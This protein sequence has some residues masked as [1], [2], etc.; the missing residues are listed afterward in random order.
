V[1]VTAFA[2]RL[3]AIAPCFE[4]AIPTLMA[5]C[6]RDGVPNISTVSHVHRVDERRVAI[7]RQF[8]NKTQAN[9]RENPQASI[10]M[11]DPI[12]LET[13]RLALRFD[14]EETSGPLFEAM[15]ARLAAIASHVGMTGVFRLQASVVFEVLSVERVEGT[16]VDVVDAPPP[17][18]AAAIDA[19]TQ[20]R[21]LRRIS[22]CLRAT[23]DAEALLDSVLAIL[24]EV[25]GFEH[26]MIL[27]LDETG[28]RLY[29][30]ASRGYPESG[31][32][33]EVRLGEGIIGKVAQTRRLLRVGNL[34]SEGR[35]AR[36]ARST[37]PGAEAREI[38]LP[39]LADAASQLAIPLVAQ[40]ELLGVLAVESR[41]WARY[42]ERDEAFLDVVAGHVALG[43][44]NAVRQA[45]AEPAPAVATASPARA[46]SG[47][48]H[49]FAFYP[50]DDCVFLDG[51]YL[52]RNVPG[53]ILWK[54]LEAYTKGG[55][56]DFTNREL[57]LDATLGL[58]ELRDNLESRLILLRKR[59]AERCEGVRIVSAGRGRF[60]LEVRGAI[61]LEERA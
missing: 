14:H 55:R 13:Y 40:D 34:A 24:E 10:A 25:L 29:T 17:D 3:E 11:T 20:L 48:A 53:R 59:L 9:L 58:P 61:E 35:Y 45:D 51:E 2:V 41:G 12:S 38:P 30:V 18:G 50:K 37:V 4:G 1:A 23:S 22:E 15:E 16:L 5:T 56:T 49:R 54:L 57:R 28:G 43:L 7:S 26:S 39:G 8:F 32:G 44:R 46:P 27:L 33:A 47:P 36:A 21:T 31:V 60:T 42:G 6:S 19:M 52:V